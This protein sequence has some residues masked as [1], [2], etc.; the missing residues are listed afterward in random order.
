MSLWVNRSW[1]H[2]DISALV[3]LMFRYDQKFTAL[4]NKVVFPFDIR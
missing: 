3:K 4:R 1:D 2:V